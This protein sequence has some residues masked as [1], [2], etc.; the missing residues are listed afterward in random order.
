[1]SRRV[2]K[3]WP[4]SERSAN[5]VEYIAGVY[6]HPRPFT[7]W[8]KGGRQAGL[9]VRRLV[10]LVSRLRAA[11]ERLKPALPPEAITA[12]VPGILLDGLAGVGCHSPISSKILFE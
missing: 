9:R 6:R 12:A 11:F 5:Q 7:Q 10:V 3:F 2:L 4:L 1:M 8:E